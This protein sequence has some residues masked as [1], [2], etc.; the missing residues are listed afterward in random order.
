[1]DL[2]AWDRGL[3]LAVNGLAGHSRVLDGIVVGIANT[4]L[5]GG[6]F[7]FVYLWW[8][9]FLP[10]RRDRDHRIE[11]VRIVIGLL[12]AVALARGLQLLLPMRLRPLHEPSLSLVTAFGARRDVL[13]HW[14]SFPSDHAVV[15]FALAT[16]MAL[17]SRWLGG[18][19]LAV[20]L[21]LACLPRVYLGYH[22]PSDILAGA[23]LGA[24]I[25]ALALPLPLPPA[26]MAA[27]VGLLRGERR[28]PEFFYPVAILLTWELMTLFNEVRLA[29]RTL[30]AAMLGHML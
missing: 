15:F 22:Y 18:L 8:L 20:A 25:I 11:V 23:A 10:P 26:L 30:G 27:A 14:S 3:L 17:R 7:L 1:M 13:E 24:L 21:V 12:L 5:A 4:D 9:W 16:A 6:G 2:A 19:G 29:G 28:R